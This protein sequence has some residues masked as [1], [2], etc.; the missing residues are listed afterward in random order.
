MM[1]YSTTPSRALKSCALST[2]RWLIVK[3]R[4]DWRQPRI[5]SGG[6][7]G[8]FAGCFGRTYPLGSHMMRVPPSAQAANAYQ[9]VSDKAQQCLPALFGVADE[10]GLRQART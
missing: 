9:V 4:P 1:K 5:H 10:F 7:P 8:L 3:I 2:Q 6:H